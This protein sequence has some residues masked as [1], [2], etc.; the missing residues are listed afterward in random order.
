MILQSCPAVLNSVKSFRNCQQ[1]SRISAEI[2]KQIKSVPLMPMLRQN[3]VKKKKKKVCKTEVMCT[4][5][6]LLFF[7]SYAHAFG[8]R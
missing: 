7:C 2:M 3:N 8:V 5:I 1:A 6:L 4:G